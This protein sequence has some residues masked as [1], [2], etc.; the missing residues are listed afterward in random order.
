MTETDKIKIAARKSERMKLN[1]NGVQ[2]REL[3]TISS[4]INYNEANPLFSNYLV[5]IN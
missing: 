4:G 5:H 3:I 1:K 2:R